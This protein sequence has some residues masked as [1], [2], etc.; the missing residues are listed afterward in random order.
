MDNA[1]RSARPADLNAGLPAVSATIASQPLLIVY[2]DTHVLVAEKPSGLVVHPAYR[3]ADGTFWNLLLALF[4]ARGSGL[5]PY[6][7]HRLDRDTSGLLCIPK[8]AEANRRL[9]R[10]LRL[11]RFSKGYLALVHGRPP[12][13]GLIDAPLARDPCDRRLVRVR[14]DGQPARTHYRTLRRLPGYTLLRVR[15][16][17][18]RTHQIR[19][20]L[21]ALGHPLAGDPLYSAGSSAVPRLFLHADALCFP[22]PYEPRTIACRSVLPRELLAAFRGIA[23]GA[24]SVRDAPGM[25]ATQHQSDCRAPTYQITDGAAVG[26]GDARAP[27][28]DERRRS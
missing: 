13:D 17:T 5:R 21:A 25:A 20:H 15:L 1:I 3:H 23:S 12:H 28:P 8:H 27:V 10:A 9:A 26:S 6:L 7:L 18:G 4:E 19:A 2:E 14:A 24:A 22:H 11:G 16:E